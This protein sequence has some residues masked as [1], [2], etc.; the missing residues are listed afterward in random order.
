M[1]DESCIKNV[2][3][4]SVNCS[5]LR[6]TESYKQFCVIMNEAMSKYKVKEDNFRKKLKR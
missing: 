4:I 3:K 6:V 5:N 1:S 2:K